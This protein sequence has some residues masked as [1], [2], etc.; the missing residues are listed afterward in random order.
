MGERVD[1]LLLLRSRELSDK[2]CVGAYDIDPGLTQLRLVGL[3][4]QVGSD[5]VCAI[6]RRDPRC[7]VDE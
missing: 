5:D 3:A 1:R 7:P 4:F 6:P 2:V